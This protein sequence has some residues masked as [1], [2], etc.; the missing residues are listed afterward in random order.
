MRKA[1]YDVRYMRDKCKGYK[2]LLSKQKDA[3]I[4]Q[5]SEQQTNVNAFL[6]TAVRFY[7]KEKKQ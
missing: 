4:I 7:M 3:D 6:K 5:A 2:L 1:D